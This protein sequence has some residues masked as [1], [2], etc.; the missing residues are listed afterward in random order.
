[1]RS[2]RKA[3]EMVDRNVW[4]EAMVIRRSCR[5]MAIS[6]CALLEQAAQNDLTLINPNGYCSQEL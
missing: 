3:I 4:C 6:V 5:V 2:E 1:V